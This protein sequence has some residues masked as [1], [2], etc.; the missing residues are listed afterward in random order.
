M[1]INIGIIFILLVIDISL[2]I[3]KLVIYLKMKQV[4]NE[5]M[6][7]FPPFFVIPSAIGTIFVSIFLIILK[8]NF[9][10]ED[11][12]FSVFTI[13]YFLTWIVMSLQIINIKIII[14]DKDLLIV[15]FFKKQNY[16]ISEIYSLEKDA[17]GR[18]WILYSKEKKRLFTLKSMM[19]N[20]KKFMDYLEKNDVKVS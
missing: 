15:N 3:T 4:E 14:K 5:F 8:I 19:I 1:G 12:F 6:I 7:S 9:F 13:I 11:I 10:K 18:G 17:F 2:L 16:H 20:R